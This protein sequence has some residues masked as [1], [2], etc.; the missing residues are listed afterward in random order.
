MRDRLHNFRQFADA[1]A[2]AAAAAAAVYPPIGTWGL[3]YLPGSAEFHVK[4]TGVAEVTAGVARGTP[5]GAR[6]RS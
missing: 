1:A 6:G 3:W 5:G 2:A 4:W